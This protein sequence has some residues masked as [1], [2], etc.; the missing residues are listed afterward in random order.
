MT[1][2]I[3]YLFTVPSLL[4]IGYI[5]YKNWKEF[6]QEKDGA[7]HYRG[8]LSLVTIA[9]LGGCVGI[10]FSQSLISAVFISLVPIAGFVLYWPQISK[11]WPVVSGWV[12]KVLSLVARIKGA[13]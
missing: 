7:N 8:A 12:N 5:Q 10:T 11:T 2:L 6:R 3:L 13:K 1:L 4:I 9:A